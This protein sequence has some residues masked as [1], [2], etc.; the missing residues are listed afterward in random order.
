MGAEFLRAQ[1]ENFV[2]KKESIDTKDE[3]TDFC[4]LPGGRGGKFKWLY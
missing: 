2:A 4:A 1:L 3:S